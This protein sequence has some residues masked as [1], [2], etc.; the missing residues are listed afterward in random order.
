MKAEPEHLIEL[1]FDNKRQYQIPVYQRNYDW[2]KDNCLE[3]YNDVIAAYD[4]EKSHFMGT[5]VQVQKEE[6]HGIKHYIIID[7]Q[8][9]MTSV[10]LF[11]KALFDKCKS[12]STKEEIEGYLYNSSQNHEYDKDEKS[13]LKL[14]P[15]KT[16]NEQFLLLMNNKYD[17]MDKSSNI[18]IN[19][20]YFCNLIDFANQYE[21]KN[22]LKGLKYLEIVMISLKE[23]EDDPQVI[24]ER[25][26]S[27]GEDLTLADL[28]RNYLLMTDSNM[29]LLYEEYWLPLESLL[30]RDRINDYF[31]NYLVFKLP[32]VTVKNGYQQ[33]KKYAD[34]VSHVDVLKDLNVYSKYY[35]AFENGNSFYSDEVNNLLDGYRVLKQTTIYP[36]FFSVFFDH[37]KRIIDDDSLSS[38]LFF[39][40]NYTLRRSITGVPTNSLRGLYKTLY[41]RIFTTEDK[42]DYANRIFTFM[43]NIP[44]TKDVMP[45]DTT[46]KDKL[47]TENIYKNGNVCK[48]ILS[49]LEN[50]L[51][52]LKEHVD[53]D[54]KITIEHIMP[55]NDNPEWRAEIG[56][57]YNDVV[58]RCLNTLGNLTLT[59]YNSELSDKSFKEKIK[60]YSANSKFIYLNQDVVNNDYWD[61]DRIKERANRLSSKIV[62][63]FKLPSVFGKALNQQVMSDKHN[64]NDRTSLT[65]SKPKSFILLGEHRAVSSFADMLT[66]AISILYSLDTDK[67][68]ALAKHD[69]AL[70]NGNKPLL[71]FDSSLMR[72]PKEIDNSGVFIETNHSANTIIFVIK[73]MLNEFGLDYDDFIFYT[74]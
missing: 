39:F 7:G 37:E 26:N 68:N 23:P 47:M 70:P 33:F 57:N 24:F 42:S 45:N 25:I 60:M 40:L 38:I 56:A 5:I 54:D 21:I 55:Q 34:K 15:I 11:L 41:K 20:D 72:N 19:Y 51:T 73:L 13:K 63:D 50:G 31:S 35:N 36:F 22:I 12:D 2:K 27:T 29:E 46:F 64:L 8:Q 65:G 43:A 52:S 6:E 14:K 74:E 58:S 16:D 32:E 66:N 59:G 71:S 61:E 49:M 53:I 67:L 9:R 30:G 44:S 69:F 10:Y 28:I 4:N 1:M 3:L 48:Y 17:K 18:F 62:A